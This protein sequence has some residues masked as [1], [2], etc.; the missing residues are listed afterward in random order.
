MFIINFGLNTRFVSKETGLMRSSTGEASSTVSSCH[1]TR[2]SI[3]KSRKRSCGVCIAQYARRDESCYRTNPAC[4]TAKCT[5][6][7]W[8]NRMQVL[9]EF[10]PLI[11]RQTML[12]H[13]WPPSL[14]KHRASYSSNED[15]RFRWLIM[16]THY[17][18][19]GIFF[20]STS[21]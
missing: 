18:F 5:C 6:S 2:R 12:M 9:L 21:L 16:L 15:Q 14:T 7:K 3:S 20:Y 17:F 11:L 8:P 10:K 4:F 19:A 1:T 13:E